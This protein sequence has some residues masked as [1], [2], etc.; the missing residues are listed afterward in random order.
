MIRRVEISNFKGI[1]HGIVDNLAQVNVIIGRN[2]SCKSSF[3]EALHLLGYTEQDSEFMYATNSPIRKI[4]RIVNRNRIV[5][6]LIH[7]YVGNATITATMDDKKDV[8]VTVPSWQFSGTRIQ[9]ALFDRVLLTNWINILNRTWE[10]LKRDGRTL[11]IIDL[12]SKAYNI[13]ELADIEYTP[14][15]NWLAILKRTEG[16][17]LG[18]Y[19]EQF[20][21]GVKPALA[22]LSLLYTTQP[23]ILLIEDFENHQHP[24][25]LKEISGV[26]VR[27]A[28]NNGAQLFFVTHSLDLV[29]AVISSSKEVGAESKVFFFR[30][31]NGEL[32]PE[33]LEAPSVQVVTEL[34]MDVRFKDLYI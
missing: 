22:L 11:E 21:D 24:K 28:K 30:V 25:A 10:T 26:L 1:Q 9:T 19:L 8:S 6:N 29:N 15:N 20:G 32:K 27:Y 17:Q 5:D 3:L 23:R 4:D 14:S 33:V 7:R 18:Y 12:L 31:E 34:G 2:N 16:S 13:P